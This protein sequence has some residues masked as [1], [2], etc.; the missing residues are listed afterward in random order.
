MKIK[1]IILLTIAFIN[2]ALVMVLELT[3]ARLIA[4]Y[5]GN[6]FFVWSSLISVILA[7]LS[8]GYYLGG[9]LADRSKRQEILFKSIWLSG[10]AVVVM[11]FSKN[12]IIDTFFQMEANEYA[13]ILL[14][15]L[16]F[17]PATLAFGLI[18]PLVARLSLH[19]L[20]DSGQTIGQIYALSTAGS[21][22]GTLLTGYALFRFVGSTNILLLILGAILVELVL[23]LLILSQQSRKHLYWLLVLTAAAV[24]AFYYQ[25]KQTSPYLAQ[26]DT[27]YNHIIVADQEVNGETVRVL[28]T[29]LLYSQSSI[30][31]DRPDW[32]HAPYHRVFIEAF[33]IKG[34]QEIDKVLA[35]GSGG[36]IIPSYLTSHY[37]NLEI[38]AVEIDK[39]LLKI[40]EEYFFFKNSDN[41]TVHTTDGRTFLQ[42]LDPNQRYDVIYLDVFVSKYI[43]FH[44][45]TKEFVSL[46]EEHLA[47][48]GLVMVN[49][50]DVKKPLK[51]DNFT[52]AV[53]H[54]FGTSFDFRVL[55]PTKFTA[56]NLLQ[57]QVLLA[58]RQPV[59]LESLQYLTDMGKYFSYAWQPQSA[60]FILTDELAP[61][62]HLF[63][64]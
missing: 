11:V 57:N 44:L 39:D 31:L 22:L 5:F 58:A 41:V 47:E 46:L 49:L 10:L 33:A 51:T 63:A 35:I 29:D 24:I 25:L 19:E 7:S 40:A 15:T 14:T 54:T 9:K 28:Q 55:I 2:G 59:D 17:G 45:I 30:I 61:V 23:A 21:I 36:F 43:P 27:P 48:D 50:V 56:E 42:R 1:K 38:D 32:L 52:N 26:F 16:L 64:Y 60:P 62:D 8:L 34:E 12:L 18:S 3:G 4:P 37:P 6:T 13:L 53:Y 20:K